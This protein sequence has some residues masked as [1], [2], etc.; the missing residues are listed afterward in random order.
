MDNVS[1][2]SN[3][4]IKQFKFFYKINNKENQAQNL[5]CSN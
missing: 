2:G 1:Q 3:H 4:T 5:F